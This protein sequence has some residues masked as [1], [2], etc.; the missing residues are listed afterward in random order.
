[1]VDSLIMYVLY[2]LFPE[3]KGNGYT[4]TTVKKCQHKRR[5]NVNIVVCVFHTAL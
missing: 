5:K 4:I 2:V 1:M 3:K